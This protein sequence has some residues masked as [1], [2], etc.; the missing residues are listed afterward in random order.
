[1]AANTFSGITAGQPQ[2]E[3]YE[4]AYRTIQAQQRALDGTLIVHRVASKRTW[5]GTWTKM[6]L[7]DSKTFAEAVAALTAP[8]TWN[9]ADDTTC[10]VV[11]QNVTRT[12]VGISNYWAVVVEMEEV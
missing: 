11:I 8:A 1:M 7:A 6:S 4:I 10:S 5:K 3:G 2:F 9:D 12:P